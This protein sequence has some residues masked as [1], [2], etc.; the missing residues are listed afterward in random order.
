MVSPQ[1]TTVVDGRWLGYSGVGRVTEALLRGLSDLRP[2][3]EWVLW[4]PSEVNRFAWK[5]VRVVETNRSPVSWLGQ[6]GASSRPSGD[7]V[8][9]MHL[10]RPL[11][12]RRRG[13]L[14]IA[15]DTIPVRWKDPRWQRPL[16]RA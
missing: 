7:R 2:S 6:R 16:Q 5:G 10:V 3:G 11:A 9:F 15:H 8:I 12:I 4:G 1:V 13:T 14:V